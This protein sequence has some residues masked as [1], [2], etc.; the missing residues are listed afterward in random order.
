MAED[1]GQWPGADF[2]HPG[3]V[4]GAGA[5][6]DRPRRHRQLHRRNPPRRCGPGRLAPGL[7]GD[8][9]SRQRLDPADRRG[10]PQR[11]G[12]HPGDVLDPG[13]T[14]R[15]RLRPRLPPDQ[16]RLSGRGEHHDRRP[17]PA[18]DL[19]GRQHRHPCLGLPEALGLD[20]PARMQLLAHY[21][22]LTPYRYAIGDRTGPFPRLWL[23]G[24]EVADVREATRAAKITREPAIEISGASGVPL[25][26]AMATGRSWQGHVPGPG[27]RPGGYPVA[28]RDG[29]LSLDLPPG[30]GEAEAVAW[31]AAF[32]RQSGLH[33]DETGRA[34]YTG[35]LHEKLKA[36]SPA[37]AEGFAVTDID[38]VF[39][40]TEALRAR[41][42]ATPA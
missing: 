27:G 21:Q 34:H 39:A 35:R 30:V 18:G 32:E 23:G 11:H 13:G 17:G 15:C 9:R 40:E 8:R 19:R 28:F 31:N 22:T 20:D 10:R 1:R 6:H 7:G 29:A 16:L 41:L 33:V 25:M 38:A 5:G 12:R 42:I 24:E 36:H 4:R 3:A 2:R 26:V 14:G 37:L